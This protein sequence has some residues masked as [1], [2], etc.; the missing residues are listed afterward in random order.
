M[1]W[2]STGRYCMKDVKEM[3]TNEYKGRVVKM[4]SVG[5]VIYAAIKTKD[6]KEIF[7]YVGL[8]STQNNE[9]YLKD[10]D[11]TCGPL[12]SNCPETILKLLT[13]TRN[14]YAIEWRERC[15]KTLE[16][17]KQAKKIQVNAIIKFEKE[18]EFCNGKQGSIFT[19]IEK[20]GIFYSE[21]IGYC[22]IKNWKQK[23]FEVVS[24]II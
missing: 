15:K 16:K 20:K 21:D 17:E 5:K 3:I 2:S 11:E 22:S 12:E 4:S 24:P 1:G 7:G 8:T 10:L 19:L 18:V 23:V 6:E 13:P 9:F 14:K